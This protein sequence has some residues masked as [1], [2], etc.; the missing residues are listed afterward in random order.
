MAAI[1]QPTGPALT[2]RDAAAACRLSPRTIRRKL[3]AGVVPER[4]QDGLERTRARRDLDDPARRSR[5]GR[6]QPHVRA[7]DALEGRAAHREPSS[8]PTPTTTARPCSS[9]FA[10]TASAAC[11][12]SSPKRS[13]RPRSRCCAPRPNAGAC[14][15][16]NARQALDRADT[17]L[18][19]LTT[20]MGSMTAIGPGPADYAQTAPPPRST[21]RRGRYPAPPAAT[22]APHA[23]P[24]PPPQPQQRR[25]AT[26]SRCRRSCAPKRCATRRRCTRCTRRASRRS[27][28]WQF[29]QGVTGSRSARAASRARTCC[30]PAPDRSRAKL[31]VRSGRAATIAPPMSN[32]TRPTTAAPLLLPVNASVPVGNE[33]CTTMIAPAARA[34]FDEHDAAARALVDDHARPAA[35]TAL[36]DA[37]WPAAGSCAAVGGGG[38]VFGGGFVVCGVGVSSCRLRLFVNSIL[39]QQVARAAARAAAAEHLRE[40]QL[41]LHDEALELARR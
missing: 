12:P 27:Q 35:G 24:Q 23:Q 26:S 33:R 36:H 40:P 7:P 31:C 17:A 21:P 16:T 9:S 1:N 41:R 22:A 32:A 25:R 30:G 4:V 19:A 11:A 8:N 5:S 3:T 20:A 10:P 2:V 28:W 29:W 34:A 13:P 39:L 37:R 15:P 18:K 14:S 38:F 6:P